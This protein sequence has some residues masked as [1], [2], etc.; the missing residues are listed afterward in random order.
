MDR[1]IQGSW[2]QR[3]LRLLDALKGKKIVLCHGCFDCLHWGHL[4]HLENAKS[5]GD[6]L[7]VTITADRYIKKPG[8]PIFREQQRYE[9]LKALRCVDYVTIIYD[10]GAEPAISLI[11]P[12][13]YVKGKEYEGTL[14]EQQLVES[15]GGKVIFTHD[16]DASRIKTTGLLRLTGDYQGIQGVSDR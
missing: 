7:W 9:M 14:P 16:E 13:F 8:R 6:K 11:K 15:Y 3:G 12:A 1:T 2:L 10:F 5:Y 4:K